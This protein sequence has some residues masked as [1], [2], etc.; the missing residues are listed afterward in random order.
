MAMFSIILSSQAIGDK[1]LDIHKLKDDFYVYTTYHAFDGVPFPSNS[2]YVV[3]DKGIV[4]IDTPWDPELTLPLVD[5]IQKVHNKKVVMCLVTHFH[6]DRTAGLDYLK[7]LG[8]KTYGTR[9][10]KR[11]CTENNEKCPEYGLSRDTTFNIGNY[12][13]SIYYPGAGHSPDNIVVWFEKEK[14]LYG[15]CFIKSTEAESLGN[16]EDANI[17][18][19][20]IN[21]K[22]LM[23]KYNDVDYVIP[24]HFGW[25][26][27]KSMKY[28]IKLLEEA[29]KNPLRRLKEADPFIK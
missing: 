16:L 23:K 4:M 14:I 24:G 19:W 28:T 13:F 1:I 9:M 22:A 15:G 20:L 18:Q 11:L 25:E 8:I 2:M 21:T 27:K 6:D 7:E 12:S 26:D 10:T 3:T 29:V 5:S 17:D